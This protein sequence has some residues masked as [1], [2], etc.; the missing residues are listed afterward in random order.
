MVSSWLRRHQINHRATRNERVIF[1]EV[2]RVLIAQNDQV[3]RLNNTIAFVTATATALLV[4][5]V[6]LFANAGDALASNRVESPMIAGYTVSDHWLLVI[7]FGI[8]IVSYVLVAFGIFKAFRLQNWRF[9]PQPDHLFA[10]YW[11]E[12]EGRTIADLTESMVSAFNDNK[13]VVASKHHWV[14]CCYVFVG[15][16]GILLLAGVFI[17]VWSGL[18]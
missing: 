14:S 4:G 6:A 2:R 1:E 3:D 7:L 12:S 16:E 15:V 13:P 11:R 10:E 18:L 17:G 8:A 9:A 5:F